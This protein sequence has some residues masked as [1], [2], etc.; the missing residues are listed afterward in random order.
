MTVVHDYP[1]RGRQRQPDEEY[2]RAFD[3]DPDAWLKRKLAWRRSKKGIRAL[4]INA[5]QNAR[6]DRRARQRRGFA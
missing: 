1:I 4:E 3:R 5:L 2:G 6:N